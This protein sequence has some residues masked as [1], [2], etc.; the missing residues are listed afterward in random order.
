MGIKSR[1]ITIIGWLAKKIQKSEAETKIRP[2]ESGFSIS[3]TRDLSSEI[4]SQENGRDRQQFDNVVPLLM[5]SNRYKNSFQEVEYKLC[6]CPLKATAINDLELLNV[7]DVISLCREYYPDKRN[8]QYWLP[9]KDAFPDS[10]LHK[11]D[12][13]GQLKPLE[14]SG[15]YIGEVKEFIKFVAD[16]KNI[17][18]VF[19]KDFRHQNAQKIFQ[20]DSCIGN[21]QFDWLLLGAD[22]VFLFEVGMTKNEDSPETTLNNK[23]E[24]CATKIIPNFALILH[25]ITLEWNLIQNSR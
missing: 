1:Q 18:G 12:D 14:E 6:P 4:Q 24:Q 13:E 25:S 8:Q 10:L 21:F 22:K 2:E 11:T 17:C 15:T 7:E 19:I 3:F 5:N 9:H 23:I 20:E 16:I